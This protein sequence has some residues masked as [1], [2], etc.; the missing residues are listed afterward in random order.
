MPLPSPDAIAD[1]FEDTLTQGEGDAEKV[2]WSSAVGQQARFEALLE[3]LNPADYGS[4]LRL[5]D[6]GCGM[7]DLYAWLK[8]T[9]R[10]VN[11]TGVDIAQGMV[12]EA[13]RRHPGGRFVQGDA[14]GVDGEFDVIICSGTFGVRFEAE[15]ESWALIEGLAQR[16][17]LVLALNLLVQPLSEAEGTLRGEYWTVHPTRAYGR[18][19]QISPKLT[20]REDILPDE[21]IVYLYQGY[22]P[23]LSNPW[24]RALSPQEAGELYM[25]RGD[26]PRVLDALNGVPTPEE[27]GLAAYHHVMVGAGH[28]LKGKVKRAT[29]SFEAAVAADPTDFRAGASLIHLY[30]GTGEI[31]GAQRALRQLLPQKTGSTQSRDWL[32]REVHSALIDKGRLIEAE[33]LEPFAGSP[34]MA[35]QLKG[36]R[37][38]HQGDWDEA[39]PLLNQAAEADP[40]D[41][42]VNLRRAHVQMARGQVSQAFEDLLKVLNLEPYH[43]GARNLSLQALRDRDALPPEEFEAL[44]ARLRH[45]YVLGALARHL[46][47]GTSSGEG[48]P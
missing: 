16:A 30:L 37:C 40:N 2:G 8:A 27:P 41:L 14:T 34:G 22:C 33:E 9:G 4:N 20:L 13:R 23:S 32:L 36:W 43:G 47:E 10:E 31:A 21:L 39:L 28:T 29:T 48:K 6:V 12:D 42:K 17:R 35:A 18:L 44:L 45:H 15:E 19:R 38:F 7:G 3:C 46:L 25:L 24:A 1:F 26:G 5:L 11:Y